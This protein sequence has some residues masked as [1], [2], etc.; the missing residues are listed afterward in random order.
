MRTSA[1]GSSQGFT[2]LELLVVICIIAIASAGISF[3][4]R[5]SSE[6][7]AEQEALRLVALL[8]SARAQSRL[9][10]IP[11]IWHP[12]PEGFTF[13]GIAPQSMPEKWRDNALSVEQD[14]AYSSASNTVALLLG[15]E[16]VIGAQGIILKTQ[17]EPASR[18][19]VFTNGLQPF[20]LEALG[21]P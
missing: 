8:E 16:P 6:T 5:D 21:K 2:L 19:R 10:G 18:F 12:T 15:P 3:S 13:E 7:R 4:L 17:D 20:Q 9:T 11:V 14:T 1:V